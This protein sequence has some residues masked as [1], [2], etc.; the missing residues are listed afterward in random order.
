MHWSNYESSFCLMKSA[1]GF[2]FRSNLSWQNCKPSICGQ[3]R[4]QRTWSWRSPVA[5]WLRKSPRSWRSPQ[6]GPASTRRARRKRSL[7]AVGF[8][9]LGGDT[10]YTQKN[11][12]ENLGDIEMQKKKRSFNRL[13][14]LVKILAMQEL[15][16][17][18]WDIMKHPQEMGSSGPVNT[19]QINVVS[20]CFTSYEI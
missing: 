2:P 3:G 5:P 13:V 17:A 14:C 20:P 4:P 7:G 8:S 6:P 1:S 9:G 10:W 16:G 19:L 15:L 12:W 18:G 11:V